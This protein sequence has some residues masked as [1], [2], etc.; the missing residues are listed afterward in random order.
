MLLKHT[1]DT[2]MARNI[3]FIIGQD[4]LVHPLPST[5]SEDAVN[6]KYTEPEILNELYDYFASTY[7]EHYAQ[8]KIET[9]EFISDQGMGMDFFLANVIKYAARYGKKG[10]N[11]KKDLQKIA[12]YTV[13]AI[14][15]YNKTHGSES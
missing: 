11:N 10:G 15:E 1:D 9:S 3:R 4:G 12:H 2:T 8:G 7:D 6:W 5:E 14:W 13:M